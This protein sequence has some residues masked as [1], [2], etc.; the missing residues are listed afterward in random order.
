MRSL[1]RFNPAEPLTVSASVHHFQPA[2]GFI[3][4]FIEKTESILI[5]TTLWQFAVNE[6]GWQCAKRQ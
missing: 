3:D 5:F 4:P 1:S 6:I 2:P